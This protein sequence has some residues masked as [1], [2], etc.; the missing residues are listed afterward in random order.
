MKACSRAGWAN[1]GSCSLNALRAVMSRS[2]EPAVTPSPARARISA[3]G[4][5]LVTG[6]QRP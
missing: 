2:H 4:A 1:G 5:K 6:N 3:I